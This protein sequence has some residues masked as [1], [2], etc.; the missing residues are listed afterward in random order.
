M[1]WVI[2]AA[3]IAVAAVIVVASYGVWLAH[4][5]SDVMSEVQVVA[6]NGERLAELVSQLRV[7]A[8]LLGEPP[9]GDV[10]AGSAS[11]DRADLDVR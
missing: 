5:A 11:A 8:G 4:K 6:A 2:L 7:P 3:A 10:V 1:F 9:P